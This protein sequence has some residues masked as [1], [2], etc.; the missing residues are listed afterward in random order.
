MSDEFVGPPSNPP[1]RHSAGVKPS[2]AKKKDLMRLLRT[3]Q[4]LP[5]KGEVV[6][7]GSFSLG[8]A[9]GHCGKCKWVADR[10]RLLEE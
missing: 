3:A 8:T 1:N 9:C 5:K 10:A 4:Y 6:C 7:R 2:K